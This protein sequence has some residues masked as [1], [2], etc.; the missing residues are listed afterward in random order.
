M[1]KQVIIR[2]MPNGFQTAYVRLV[3][4]NSL[5]STKPAKPYGLTKLI[6]LTAFLSLFITA[7]GRENAECT[8]ALRSYKHS[9]E[10]R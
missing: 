6:I 3:C 1:G 7:C 4:H 5:I 2:N 10:C 9:T 8:N